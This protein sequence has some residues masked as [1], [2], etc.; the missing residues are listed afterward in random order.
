MNYFLP[1]FDMIYD[2][3]TRHILSCK[4]QLGTKF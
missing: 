1:Q 2:N 3:D 4:K